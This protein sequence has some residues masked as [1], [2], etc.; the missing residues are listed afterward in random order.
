VLQSLEKLLRLK[1]VKIGYY[2]LINFITNTIM[3]YDEYRGTTVVNVA[4]MILILP[5]VLLHKKDHPPKQ[6]VLSISE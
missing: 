1:L 3:K 2:G 4:L 6:M 5:A